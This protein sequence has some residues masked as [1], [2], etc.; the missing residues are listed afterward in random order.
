MR[1]MPL[2]G[3][4]HESGGKKMNFFEARRARKAAQADARVVQAV[5]G[6]IDG[7]AVKYVTR[8]T[9][10]GEIV[11]GRRGHINCRL[12]LV[13]VICNGQEVFHAAAE[14]THCAELLNLSGVVLQANGNTVVAYYICY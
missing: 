13:T 2:K 14:E 8:R 5:M 6:R 11:L 10:E 3:F 1:G 7:K 9:S 12:G 4:L